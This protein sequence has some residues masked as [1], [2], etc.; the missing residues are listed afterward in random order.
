VSLDADVEIPPTHDRPNHQ[1][2]EIPAETPH[3]GAQARPHEGE[4]EMIVLLHA[5]AA[6]MTV[7]TDLRSRDEA[8]GEIPGI[9]IVDL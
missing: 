1:L 9:E 7:M 4:E 2:G 5:G 6:E 8:Q 3:L